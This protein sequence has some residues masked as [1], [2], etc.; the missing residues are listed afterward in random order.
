MPHIWLNLK[1]PT[2]LPFVHD[3]DAVA[4]PPGSHTKHFRLVESMTFF[5]IGVFSY[6]FPAKIR[7]NL[8][9]RYDSFVGMLATHAVPHAR[10]RDANGQS[11]TS[12]HSSPRWRSMHGIPC[13]YFHWIYIYIYIYI[14]HIHVHICMRMV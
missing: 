13:G 11:L 2:L 9:Y 12:L 10:S 1:D 5:I 4:E 7:I 8:P 3:A 6:P 14:H